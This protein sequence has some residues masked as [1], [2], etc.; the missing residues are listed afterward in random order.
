MMSLIL[1]PQSVRA[2]DRLEVQA[3][4]RD[5]AS[6]L[7]SWLAEI[8]F[9]V[10]SERWAF[11]EFGVDEISESRVRGWGLGE[12]LDLAR[13]EIQMEVKAPTYHM[14]ELKEEAGRWIVQVIFDV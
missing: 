7:V 10:E 5:S 1:N 3:E 12:P 13:H 11:R 9:K 4:G 14:L 8:L 2:V 6:L